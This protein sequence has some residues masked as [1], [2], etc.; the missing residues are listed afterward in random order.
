MKKNLA[1]L[2]IFFTLS[3]IPFITQGA[4]V[5]FPTETSNVE[6]QTKVSYFNN[7]ASIFSFVLAIIFIFSLFGFL[8]SGLTF[9]MAGGHEGNLEKARSTLIFSVVGVVISLIGYISLNLLKHFF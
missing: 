9:I 3:T 6:Q 5:E 1:T 7:I 2:F 8:I 4:F